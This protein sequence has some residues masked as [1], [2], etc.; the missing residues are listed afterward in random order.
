MIV[1]TGGSDNLTHY[2]SFVN[3]A[4]KWYKADDTKVFIVLPKTVIFVV[5]SI[6]TTVHTS[7]QF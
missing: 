2:Y 5:I 3:H 6:C 1:H 4:K 7:L